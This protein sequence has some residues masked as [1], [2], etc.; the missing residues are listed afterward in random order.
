[1]RRLNWNTLNIPSGQS[2]TKSKRIAIY[3]KIGVLFQSEIKHLNSKN[4]R[5]SIF[6]LY[7]FTMHYDKFKILILITR[8]YPLWFFTIFSRLSTVMKKNLILIMQRGQKLSKFF[9]CPK[10]QPNVFQLSKLSFQ[11]QIS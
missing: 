1:M 2:R 6:S 4:F 9:L 11:S 10:F 7:K 8:H 5:S 3:F